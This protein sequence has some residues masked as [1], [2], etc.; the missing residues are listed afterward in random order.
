MENVKLIDKAIMISNLFKDL[1]S[2]E[3]QLKLY[4]EL[5]GEDRNY[6]TISDEEMDKFFGTIKNNLPKGPGR[7]DNW[8]KYM[9]L[10]PRA[11]SK[12]PKIEEQDET[13]V[14]AFLHYA[15][16]SKTVKSQ[17]GLV[18]LVNRLKTLAYLQMFP[19]ELLSI[20]SSM[21]GPS[22]PKENGDED[23]Y[24]VVYAPTPFNVGTEGVG[25]EINIS[26]DDWQYMMAV[27]PLPDYE[28][29]KKGGFLKRSRRI[30]VK[31]KVVS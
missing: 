2:Y 10:F 9:Q 8:R 20:D 6:F 30:P 22:A 16:N 13:N 31:R 14:R 27:S 21:S 11:I 1:S 4:T 18:N 28:G 15:L 25:T 17:I 24:G 3:D 7:I 12:I 5:S 19:S 26:E 29:G 23:G